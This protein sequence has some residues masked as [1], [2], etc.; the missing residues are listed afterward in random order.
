M[1]KNLIE[2]QKEYSDNIFRNY[3]I[4][5]ECKQIIQKMFNDV[6]GH[7]TYISM[8]STLPRTVTVKG[9]HYRFKDTYQYKFYIEASFSCYKGTDFN[10]LIE[11]NKKIIAQKE[12][13]FL[14]A[15][16]IYKAFTGKELSIED[17]NLKHTST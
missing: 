8:D 9:V 11:H 2:L 14:N 16:K 6:D 3:A 7:N 12:E 5:K 15:Q 17:T 13:L 1:T 10:E 4:S